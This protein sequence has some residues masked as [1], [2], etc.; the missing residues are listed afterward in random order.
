VYAWLQRRSRRLRLRSARCGWTRST[1]QPSQ[2]QA[3]S[4]PTL[5]CADASQALASL[6]DAL[7]ADGAGCDDATLVWFLKDRKLDVAKTVEKIRSYQ[8][9]RSRGFACLT[10]ADVAAEAATGKARLLAERDVLGRP[11][12]LVKVA[13][14]RLDT[15]VLAVR[16][17]PACCSPGSDVWR[18]RRS[19]SQCF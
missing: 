5:L 6:R 17:P 1:A 7:A 18:R 3:F 4:P 16:L 19:G 14:N 8:A 12:V 9:W 15:R 13:S 10:A 2:R 11:A